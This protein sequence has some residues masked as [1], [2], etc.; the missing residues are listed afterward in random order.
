MSRFSLIGLAVL[1]CLQAAASVHGQTLGGERRPPSFATI[2]PARAAVVH[3]PS[4]APTSREH[5]LATVLKYAREEQMYLRGAVRDFTCRLV[6]RERIDGRLQPFTYIDM[7]VRE[8]VLDGE[9]IVRPQS[10]YLSFLSPDEV[11]GRK[12]LFVAG[13]NDGK[14]VVRKGGKRFSYVV[15]DIDPLGDSARQESL[16]PISESGFNHS[17]GHMIRVLEKHAQIDPAGENTRVRRIAGAKINHRLCKVICIEHTRKQ[18]GLEFHQANVFV[19]DALHVPVRIDYSD[20]PRSPGEAPSLIAEYTY[21]DLKLN[22]NLSDRA[23]DP[24]LVRGNR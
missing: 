12:V 18:P 3:L 13:E 16:V 5:P 15:T 4:T 2:E 6:K 22:V 14:M 17:L 21:T 11:A 23:F 8:E 10:I 9:R 20:W 1:I 24:T 19:D 7:R